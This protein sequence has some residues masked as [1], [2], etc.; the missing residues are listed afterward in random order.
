MSPGAPQPTMR[1]TPVLESTIDQLPS[2]GLKNARSS[3][4]S[5]SKSPRTGIGPVPAGCA[6]NVAVTVV[7][8]LSATMQPPVPLQPPPLQ[9]V[10]VD[11]GSAVAVRL[12]D[13]TML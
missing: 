2:A 4:P 10:N 6:V 12:T 5:P 7:D 9:P 8:A 13:V 1:S 11:P 3:R